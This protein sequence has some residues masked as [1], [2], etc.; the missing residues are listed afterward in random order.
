M[1]VTK[2]GKNSQFHRNISVA[3]LFLFFAMEMTA[4]TTSSYNSVASSS[5]T[6]RVG[7]HLSKHI[8]DYT[9]RQ[10]TLQNVLWDFSAMEA[11]SGRHRVRYSAA[12]NMENTI[13]GTENNCRYYYKQSADSIILCGWENNLVKVEYDRPE[14]QLVT[15]LTYGMRHEGL[16]HGSMVYCERMFF[17]IFG[18]YSAGVDATGSIILPSGDTLRHVSRIHIHRHTIE[19]HFPHIATE[20]D[21]RQYIDSIS[22]YTSDSILRH[23]TADRNIKETDTYRWY[24]AGY[25]YPILEVTTAN[26]AG[27]RQSVTSYYFP[28]EEQEGLDDADNETIRQQIAAGLYGRGT[29]YA[30]NGYHNS[31]NSHDSST[32]ATPF[33]NVSIQTHGSTISISY[34]LTTPATVT[35][36]VCDISGMVYRQTT[37]NGVTEV[38]NQLSVDCS[39][40][41]H[42]EYVLYL[43]TNGAVHSQNVSIK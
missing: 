24:A 1:H 20:K 7:D 38:S 37:Q 17:R 22:P 40:L 35:A 31:G 27:N 15:P 21:L 18:S 25:R 39:G 10:D 43:N 32:P 11:A 23:L 30:S 4:Q 34:D 8:V 9:I 29:D 5:H 3:A 16:F 28:P 2:S 14:L 33:N 26:G 13:A 36:M 19:Q 41:R 42:G 6:L 12:Y